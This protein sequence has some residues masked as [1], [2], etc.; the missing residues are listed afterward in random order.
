MAPV[1]S[2]PPPI[3]HEVHGVG[4]GG[5]NLVA[6]R[7]AIDLSI[8]SL[9]TLHIQVWADDMPFLF[10]EGTLIYTGNCQEE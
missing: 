7:A 4:T 1:G 2:S 10:V 8:N 5:N 9:S 3:K 6:F